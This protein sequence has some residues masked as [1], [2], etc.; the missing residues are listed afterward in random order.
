MK[1]GPMAQIGTRNDKENLQ[2]GLSKSEPHIRSQGL[3]KIRLVWSRPRS[4][5]SD[6]LRKRPGCN[7]KE[8]LM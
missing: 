5:T 2:A 6:A 7:V 1:T 3:K 4:V 8:Q